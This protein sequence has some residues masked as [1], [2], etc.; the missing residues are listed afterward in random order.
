MSA[1]ALGTFLTKFQ[2]WRYCPP[3]N[4]LW[5]ISILLSPRN[6]QDSGSTF[7]KLYANICS[8]N[9]KFD[10]MYSPK[11][12]ITALDDSSYIGGLQD[13]DIGLFLATDV[14][15]TPNSITIT[16]SQS[17]ASHGFTG[18]LNFGKTQTGRTHNSALKIKFYKSNWDINELLF[19]KWIAAIGQ[20]GL[21]EDSTLPNIKANIIINEYAAGVPGK[22]N[23]NTWFPK[24]QIIFTKAFPKQRDQVV[25]TYGSE[26]AGEFKSVGVDFEYE[27][28]QI[29]YYNLPAGVT[30]SNTK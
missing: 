24:K 6:D 8:V 3:S 21:I 16:D 14:S 19:D 23:K 4:H 18:F 10:N 17:G 1:N 28:Y 25:Y 30:D 5:T 7:T 26:D 22:E 27:A 9:K 15:F 29:N 13:S 2:D 11:W 20:Q 12:K